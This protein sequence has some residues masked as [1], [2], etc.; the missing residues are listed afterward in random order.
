MAAAQA[1]AVTATFTLAVR[2]REQTMQRNMHWGYIAPYY[3][4]E[5]M[6]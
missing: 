3:L 6:R 4:V 2:A 1:Q 5:H